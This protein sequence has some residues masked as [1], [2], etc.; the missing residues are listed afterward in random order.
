MSYVGVKDFKGTMYIYIYIYTHACIAVAGLGRFCHP[1]TITA[2]PDTETD[3]KGLESLHKDGIKA[4][5]GDRFKWN[6]K[7]GSAKFVTPRLSRNKLR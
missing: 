2:N 7:G 3:L 6:V 5:A 4:I 1:I